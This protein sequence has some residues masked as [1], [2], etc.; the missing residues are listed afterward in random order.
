MKKA[1]PMA[2]GNQITAA[3][4]RRRAREL[5]PPSKDH[6]VIRPSGSR[7]AVRVKGRGW[8]E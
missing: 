5:T 1:V 6:A 8:P 3:M 7:R 4:P 2:R